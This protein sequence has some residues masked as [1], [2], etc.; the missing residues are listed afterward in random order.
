VR[1]LRRLGIDARDVEDVAQDVFVVAFEREEPL[2]PDWSPRAFL[3]GV[4][5]RR[6]ADYRRLARH[7]TELG[8]ASER[9]TALADDRETVQLVHRALAR[10]PEERRDVLV[11]YEIEGLTL[12]EVALATGVPANTASSR[13]RKAREEF[14]EAIRELESETPIRA[15]A[16]P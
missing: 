1:S 4:L 14:E 11:L 9:G 8:E 15:G 2:G 5:R 12:D 3:W 10:L 13:L 16:T 6:A 7:R